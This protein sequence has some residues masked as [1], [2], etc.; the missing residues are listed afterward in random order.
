MNRDQKVP[1]HSLELQQQRSENV[2]LL[3]SHVDA[4]SAVDQREK[5]ISNRKPDRGIEQVSPALTTET[6]TGKALDRI[7]V[8]TPDILTKD[9]RSSLNLSR[10]IL[11]LY[12]D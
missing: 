10:Q 8:G 12:L 4:R 3:A 7:S 6:Y 5:T 9:F 11:R 2:W 1:S